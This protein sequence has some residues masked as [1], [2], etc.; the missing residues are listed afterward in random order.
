[1]VTAAQLCLDRGHGKAVPGS[2]EPQA[3][4]DQSYRDALQA[5]FDR[6]ESEADKPASH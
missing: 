5:L 4:E 1:M 2:K 3:K 6:L